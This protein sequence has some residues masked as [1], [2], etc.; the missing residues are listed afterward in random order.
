MLDGYA[1][2]SLPTSSEYGTHTSLARARVLRPTQISGVASEDCFAK[3]CVR[4]R[5]RVVPV[6]AATSLVTARRKPNPYPLPPTRFGVR[7]G[8]R[9]G[10]LR[11]TRQKGRKTAFPCSSVPDRAAIEC[12]RSIADCQ[13]VGAARPISSRAGFAGYQAPYRRVLCGRRHCEPGR[14]WSMPR[15]RQPSAFTRNS[16]SRYSPASNA[17]ALRAMEGKGGK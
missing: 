5:D 10:V 17:A 9:P 4:F 16:G 8:R 3:W 15:T 13:R 11:N 7:I 14:C 2:L 12:P 6:W 1:L